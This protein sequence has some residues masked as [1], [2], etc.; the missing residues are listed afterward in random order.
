MADRLIPSIRVVFEF[1]FG[2]LELKE[3]LLERYH[4]GGFDDAS[5]FGAGDGKEGC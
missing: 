5:A 1:V 3:F 2:K 4:K